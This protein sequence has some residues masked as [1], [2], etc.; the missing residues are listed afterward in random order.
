M[1]SV[2]YFWMAS[3]G[4]C[5]GTRVMWDLWYL[6][7]DIWRMD[8]DGK[9][10]GMGLGGGE[11]KKHFKGCSQTANTCLPV[12]GYADRNRGCLVLAVS[13]HEHLTCCLSTV[14]APLMSIE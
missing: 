14:G 7:C 3:L 12:R 2:V 10:Q 8:F 9:A 6:S 5:F 1:S 13:P 4:S 11:K